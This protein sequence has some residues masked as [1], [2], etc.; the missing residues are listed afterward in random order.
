MTNK[1]GKYTGLFTSIDGETI[2]A[3]DIGDTFNAV[4]TPIGGIIA[5]FKTFV[6][7]DS[8]TTSS[9][10][11]NKLVE[12][13]Q[14]FSTTV[15]VGN[16]IFNSTDGTWG[17]VTAVDNNT[18]LSVSADNFPTGKAYT[19]Y[20]TPRL[21]DAWYE[22]NGQAISDADSPFNGGTMPSLNGTTD[23]T[24]LFIRGLKNAVVGT[25][26]GASTHTHTGETDAMKGGSNAYGSGAGDL[27]NHTHDFT[28]DASTVVPVV[29]AN[30]TW[31]M[32]IK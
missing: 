14:N 32:R 16:I 30:M 26:G 24:A 22:C 20:K 6:T 17:Y 12:A 10:S 31:I 7:A 15:N 27:I 25:T 2:Y 8:G 9:T 21:P 28:T 18:T 4:Q 29:Y 23:A 11:A 1:I 19:I 13:G 5:W 3:A